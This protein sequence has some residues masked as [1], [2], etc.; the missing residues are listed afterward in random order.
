ML[1]PAPAALPTTNPETNQLAHD[2]AR[3]EAGEQLEPAGDPKAWD[4]VY[5]PEIPSNKN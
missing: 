2:R 3:D 1:P 5:G 4:V